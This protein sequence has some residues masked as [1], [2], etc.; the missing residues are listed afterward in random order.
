M[1][2]CGDSRNL[3]IND[4]FYIIEIIEYIFMIFLKFFKLFLLIFFVV[5]FCMNFVFIEFIFIINKKSIIWKK[6]LLKKDD[7][8]GL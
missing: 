5:C 4:C 7:F 1:Y 8:K 6:F 2:V 3:Y